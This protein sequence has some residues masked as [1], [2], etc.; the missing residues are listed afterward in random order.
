MSFANRAGWAGVAGAVGLSWGGAAMA[1]PFFQGIGDLTGGGV[2]S[3]AQAISAD[4]TT[5]VGESESASGPEAFRWR[6]AGGM[7]GLGDL[8]GAAF[9]SFAYDVSDDGEAVSGFSFSTAS[10]VFQEAFRWTLGGGMVGLGDVAGGQFWSVGYCISGDGLTVGGL[11]SAA[12]SQL[13]AMRW[14]QADGMIAFGDL[15]GGPVSAIVRGASTDGSILV[16]RG[17]IAPSGADPQ[18]EAFR[19]TLAGGFQPLGDLAGGLI[20]S[21][22]AACTPEGSVIVGYGTSG[23]GANARQATRWTQATG[24]VSLGD[25]PGGAMSGEALAVSNDGKTVVGYS[26]TD[27]GTEAFIWREGVGMQNLRTVLIGS[28][29]TLT[30]WVLNSATGVSGDGLTICGSGVNPMGQQEAWIARL[31]TPCP[32]DFNGDGQVNSADLALLLANWGAANPSA[33]D[34]NGDG[35]VD[36]RDLPA[37]LGSWGPCPA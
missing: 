13:N 1:A 12:G 34:V 20:E 9:R 29:L 25:L 14:T 35:E 15:P 24:M 3:A 37:L 31:R 21:S 22:A 19:W 10:G 6:A 16:G 17:A 30:G 7:I 32:A 23:S 27:L 2:R 33:G 26:S 8:P 4:G 18:G 5:V 36:S 28:G 11:V